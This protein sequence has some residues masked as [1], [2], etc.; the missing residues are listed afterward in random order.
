MSTLYFTARLNGYLQGF[1]FHPETLS[2]AQTS[3]V[4]INAKAQITKVQMQLKTM[5]INLAI[6]PLCSPALLDNIFE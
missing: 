4:M 1:S 5:L 2:T 6:L 3:G